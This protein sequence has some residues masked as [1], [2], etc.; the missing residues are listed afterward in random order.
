VTLVLVVLAMTS[1]T[2]T[3]PEASGPGPTTPTSSGDPMTR[4]ER[5]GRTWFRT[6]ATVTFDTQTHDPGEPLSQHQCIRQLWL[7]DQSSIDRPTAVRMCARQG[8]LRLV[9]DPPDRWRMDVTTPNDEYALISSP[10]VSYRCEGAGE[11]LSSCVARTSSQAERATSF[12][13]VLA[14]PGDV[15]VRIGADAHGSVTRAL[16][17]SIAGTKAECY[18]ATGVSDQEAGWCFSTTGVLMFFTLSTADGASARLEA[19]RVSLGV[20]RA[21]LTPSI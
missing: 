10:G 7:G 11:N 5:L 4:L 17:R 3:R 16:D 13:S 9:W 20:S 8:V 1:C 19:T 15:L 12:R 6:S 2:S 14:T 21:D 18:W